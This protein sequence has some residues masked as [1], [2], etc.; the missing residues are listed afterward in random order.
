MRR[1]LRSFGIVVVTSL[2]CLGAAFF[3]LRAVAQSKEKEAP[4]AQ[5]SKE[6]ES[7]T[8]K[9]DP[10]VAPD[11]RQSADNNVSFPTDI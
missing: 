2:L 11:A 8:I 6:E 7:A 4:A 9:D 5:P 3:T 1:S 10:T